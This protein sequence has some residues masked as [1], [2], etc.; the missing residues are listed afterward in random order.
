VR[1][2]KS[3]VI[4]LLGAA[5]LVVGACG[6]S[7]T[8]NPV[9][10]VGGVAAAFDTAKSGGVLK[11]MDLVTCLTTGG[12]IGSAF[13]GLF[14]GLTGDALAK[15]GV[16]PAD[17][18]AAWAISFDN[19]QTAQASLSGANATVHVS[20]K[21]TSAIDAGK[22]R[23]LVKKYA[24]TQGI[25]PD[26]ATIDAAIQAKLGGQTTMSETITKDISVVKQN[27]IWVACGVA[28]GAA[29]GGAAGAAGAAGAQPA[30]G[31]TTAPTQAAA[32]TETPTSSV[33][34]ATAT[35]GGSGSATIPNVSGSAIAIAAG[36]GFACALLSD[37][38]VMCWGRNNSGQ[39]GNGTTAASSSPVSPSGLG[40]GVKSISVDTFGSFACAVTAS[41]A[42]KCWGTGPL[43]NGPPSTSTTS[44]TAVGVSSGARSVA[45][46]TNGV[47]V[48]MTSGGVKCWGKNGEGQLGN[49]STV[50][51]DVPVD[52]ASLGGAATVAPAAGYTCALMT[53]G[54]VK[55]WGNKS[56]GSLG[57]GS[58]TGSLTPVDVVG[59]TGA[60]KA[61]SVGGYGSC[62]LAA[63]GGV[64]CWG[65]NN[66]VAT[67][68]VG[69]TSG[70]RDLLGIAG[71]GTC[72]FTTDGRTMCW[73]SDPTPK[74]GTAQFGGTFAS[75]AFG[76]SRVLCVLT[77][78][79]GVACANQTQTGWQEI[80]GLTPGSA[81][82]APG[83]TP[84]ATSGSVAAVSVGLQHT[85]VVTT[86][87]GVK[88]WGYIPGNGMTDSKTPV[89][90][91][92]LT[93][94]VSAVATGTSFSCA[95]TSSGAVKCWGDDNWGQLGNGS[96]ANSTIPVDVAGLGS[97][98]TAIAAGGTQACALIAGSGV[99]CWGHSGAL[100]PVAV[101]GLSG[102]SAISVG[103][104]SVCA[105][106]GA[107]G[108][109][110]WTFPQ[111][112]QDVPSL[113]AGVKAIDAG[114]YQCGI[115]VAG[116]VKCQSD[117]GDL[118]SLGG[119]LVAISGTCVIN[120]AGGVKCW[121]SNLGNGTTASSTTPVDVVGLSAGVRSISSGDDG[122]C[123]VTADHALMCWGSRGSSIPVNTIPTLFPGL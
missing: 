70:V 41:G 85:C 18:S 78:S 7:S 95:L 98:V 24:A 93:S 58:T 115:L 107:G 60:A 19:L 57:N 71:V 112:P 9:D 110:C 114:S 62:A 13:S 82:S 16:S 26:D 61:I 49:N 34:A 79:G 6:G 111:A 5:I 80:T 29:G 50:D 106:T 73:G 43:G 4:A 30:T 22:M 21:V 59:L 104:N 89:D 77:T 51:S 39:L 69:L 47:C 40:A 38:S 122:V 67:D 102:V 48:V 120:A 2:L 90:V 92:G 15:A 36:D 88:C 45:V 100:T 86:S 103:A 119:S 54:G 113:A 44:V 63:A 81:G 123:A 56:G 53:A 55:C 31:S 91:L 27:G 17:L 83:E 11:A 20:V 12:A 37:G 101:A 64:K 75:L 28:L 32:A 76:G 65:G 66:T 109:K 68:V 99:K 105:L 121:G 96:K 35:P 42:V 1:V 72:A 25:V 8:A 14:G 94:G 108:V 87:G 52:V 118:S 10:P 97:G 33:P 116:G 117:Q 74:D 46:A 3:K 23:D 84:A